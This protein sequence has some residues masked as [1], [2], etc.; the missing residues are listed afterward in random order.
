MHPRATN[1]PC[2]WTIPDVSETESMKT[3]TLIFVAMLGLSIAAHAQ[4]GWSLEQCR[5]RIGPEYHASNGETHYF[6]IG[7]WG[8]G[9]G[10]QL[11]L[12]FD[13]DDTVGTIQWIKLDGEAFSEAEIQQ[14]LR[15][16]SNVSWQRGNHDTGELNWIGMQNRQV[17]F[18]ANEADNGRGV[19]VLS[20]ST[21]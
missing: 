21:R 5:L 8:R 6:H 4:M 19:Y 3:I 20:I 2:K 16:A 1:R 15:E 12:S 11:Y 17:I 7:P 18:D 10:E 13:P 9:L 14:R